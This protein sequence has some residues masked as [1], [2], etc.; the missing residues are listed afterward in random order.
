MDFALPILS[1]SQVSSSCNDKTIP[2]FFFNPTIEFLNFLGYVGNQNIPVCIDGTMYYDGK[3]T[4]SFDQTTV[5]ECCPRNFDPRKPIMACFLNFTPFQLYPLKNGYLN[6][7]KF[8]PQL[9]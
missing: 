5:P 9:K 7:K 6:F 1:W 8:Y 4:V 3:Q 2:V